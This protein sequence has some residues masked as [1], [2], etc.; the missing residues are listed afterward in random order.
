MR[1][2]LDQSL[3]L[4]EAEPTASL[5]ARRASRRTKARRASDAF[6]SSLTD[7]QIDSVAENVLTRRSG[8]KGWL[9]AVVWGEFTE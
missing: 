9:I 4:S 7:S 3:V 6:A 1:P 8:T 2:D 5:T